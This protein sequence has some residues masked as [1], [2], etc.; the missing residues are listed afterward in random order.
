MTELATVELEHRQNYSHSLGH[1]APFYEALAGG[2]LV[3]T[4]CQSC[5]RAFVP[6][7][8]AC[9][10]DGSPTTW[11][12]V[13]NVGTLVAQ[14]ELS[15][16]PRYAAGGGANLVLGLVQLDGVGTAILAELVDSDRS[17]ATSIAPGQ[18]VQARFRPATTHPAQH[19]SFVALGPSAHS[20]GDE[21]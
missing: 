9:V 15:R 4:R 16:R 7:R 1:N 2:S 8:A 18:R 14:S 10:V 6:P 11:E 5:G 21:T 20:E 13:G 17:P 3:G 19:L 12:A